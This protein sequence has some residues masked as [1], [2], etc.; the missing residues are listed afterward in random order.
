ML[1][2]VGEEGLS[3][4]MAA[5]AA[6]GEG[7]AVEPEVNNVFEQAVCAMCEAIDEECKINLTALSSMPF[8]INFKCIQLIV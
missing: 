3:T 4:L 7:S 5:V 8:G 2:F 6:H 1:S